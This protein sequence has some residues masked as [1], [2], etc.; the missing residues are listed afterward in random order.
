VFLLQ[1][2]ENGWMEGNSGCT[3]KSGRN[4]RSSVTQGKVVRYGDM[5]CSLQNNSRGRV[6]EE[7]ENKKEGKE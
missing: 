7:K 4:A 2:G 3:G 1:E 5:Y 6:E